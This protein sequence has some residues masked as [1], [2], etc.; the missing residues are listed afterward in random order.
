LINRDFAQSN[1]WTKA[2]VLFQIGILGIADFKLDLIAQLFNPDTLIR[3]VS[4]WALYKLN[5]EEYLKN[6][7]RLGE[8]MQKEL[9]A[10]ILHSR[11]KTRFELVLF[12]QKNNF[13]ENVPGITLSYLADISEEVRMRPQDS[14]PLDEKQNNNFYVMISGAVD[15][16]QRGEKVSEFETG[17]FIGEMLGL[18]NFVNTNLI[19]AKTDVVILKFN[20]DQFY[21][22]LSDN[23]KLA[24]KV[25]EY[26]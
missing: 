11:K 25:L 22:L 5:P 21:E 26:I 17:Q 23:V 7:R 14:L 24:D 12:F 8:G 4:A 10:L 16:Y 9:D 3:E 20:K 13:F 18:P 6:T 2:C 15:F 19:I 1:R